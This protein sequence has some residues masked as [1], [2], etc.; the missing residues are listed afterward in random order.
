MGHGLDRTGTE[1]CAITFDRQTSFSDVSNQGRGL[2]V[3]LCPKADYRNL[4]TIIDTRTCFCLPA[5]LVCNIETVTVLWRSQCLATRSYRHEAVSASCHIS[6]VYF[7]VSRVSRRVLYR[8]KGLAIYRSSSPS[9][10]PLS[11]GSIP[12]DYPPPPPR[13]QWH[14]L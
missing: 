4:T 10:P 13:H 7:N 3:I 9:L 5:F 1:H 12:I 11:W 14:H 8:H 2:G 6:L